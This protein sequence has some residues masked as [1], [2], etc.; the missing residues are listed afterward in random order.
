MAKKMHKIILYQHHRVDGGTRTAVTINGERALEHFVPGKKPSDPVILWDWDLRCAGARLPTDPAKAVGWLRE[1]EPVVRDE[2]TRLADKVL[3]SGKHE[4]WPL[5]WDVSHPPR[6]VRMQ[7]FCDAIRPMTL[8][9][10]A[11]N[12]RDVRDRWED[13]LS[14]LPT[15]RAASA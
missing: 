1:Q 11:A 6:G 12:L 8:R 15:T 4:D 10:L 5:L 2:L 14:L 13:I 7:L 9:R 3:T